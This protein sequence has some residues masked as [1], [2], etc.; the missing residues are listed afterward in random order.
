MSCAIKVLVVDDA[1]TV[2]K[3]VALILSNAGYDVV[4]ACDGITA[5]RLCDETISLAIVDVI[6]PDVDG[7]VLAESLPCKV[8]LMSG[9]PAVSDLPFLGKPFSPTQLLDAVKATV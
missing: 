9:G 1:P 4:E 7:V 6:L 5:R 2:L 3:M 8:L